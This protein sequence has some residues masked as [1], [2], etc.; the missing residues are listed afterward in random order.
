MSL[1]DH[2]LCH[3]PV[4]WDR[5][6]E[7][8]TGPAPLDIDIQAILEQERKKVSILR[9]NFKRQVRPHDSVLVLHPDGRLAA[10]VLTKCVRYLPCD[11]NFTFTS[12]RKQYDGFFLYP[13]IDSKEAIT[14]A[15]LSRLWNEQ[16]G[17]STA[18]I[19]VESHD[20]RQQTWQEPLFRLDR[21]LLAAILG[22]ASAA[23]ADR[24]PATRA[25][26]S[27]SGSGNGEQTLPTQPRVPRRLLALVNQYMR[28]PTTQLL[29]HHLGMPLKGVAA[30]GS[31]S[32][33]LVRTRSAPHWWTSAGLRTCIMGP[34][35]APS[36][37][38]FRAISLSTLV[39]RL[40]TPALASHFSYIMVFERD[41]QALRMIWP[42]LNAILSPVVPMQVPNVSGRGK[43]KLSNVLIPSAEDLIML[44]RDLDPRQGLVVALQSSPPALFVATDILLSSST[45][46]VDN[47]S[48]L[49]KSHS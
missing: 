17:S 29:I 47:E 19:P 16:G 44:I 38:F 33:R 45:V 32:K 36:S 12:S 25:P 20:G 14:G 42:M 4:T 26:G 8:M 37:N 46:V 34:L 3:Q 39:H 10:Q 2:Q 13:S 41:D 15:F 9:F 48:T 11:R 22:K 28:I 1:D 30:A 43:G 6:D 5:P 21:D 24:V 35:G 18:A 40:P 27:G 23:A 7:Q 31:E 49:S